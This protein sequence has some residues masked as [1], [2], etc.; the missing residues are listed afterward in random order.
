MSKS[1]IPPVM[2]QPVIHSAGTIDETP[3]GE[4]VLRILR[5]HL[6]NCNCRWEVGGLCGGIHKL[7]DTMNRHQD[8]RARLL[9]RA[10][11]ILEMWQDR[12]EPTP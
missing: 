10:I 8:E 11:G 6:E 7:Y 4:Y 3:D 12:Q 1:V 9:E 2:Q 5:A